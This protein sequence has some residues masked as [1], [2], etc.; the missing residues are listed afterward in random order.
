MN[1]TSK[2]SDDGRVPLRFRVPT[3]LHEIALDE[4]PDKRIGLTY[5]LTARTLPSATE[6]ERMHFT[7]MQEMALASLVNEGC[8]YAAHCIA[9]SAADPAKLSLGMFT[10]LVK[11]ADLQA[12]RPLAAI[13]GGLRRPGEPKEIVFADYPAGEALVIGE[14]VKARLPTNVVG[15]RTTHTSVVR[16]A[17]VIFALPSRQHLAILGV[18]SESIEDWRHYV[19]MLNGIAESM[20]FSRSEDTGIAARLRTLG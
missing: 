16:Q 20:S 6:I 8:V 4:D 15:H 2:L 13:A 14:E 19:A 11:K 9:H 12:E 18:S 17:Q 3:Q 1:I 5:Q 10:V 7:L